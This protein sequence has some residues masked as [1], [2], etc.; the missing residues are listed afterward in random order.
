VIG[1][2]AQLFLFRWREFVRE[3]AVL[4]W[5][6]IFPLCMMGVL[7]I[8]FRPKKAE[9]VAILVS[10]D[11]PAGDRIAKDLGASPDVKVI[12][13]PPA[14]ALAAFNRGEAPLL[15]LP[16]EPPTYRYD[17]TH[18][19]SRLARLVTDGALEDARGRKPAFVATSDTTSTLGARYIDWLV[20]GII[21][22]QVMNGALWGVG[23]AIVEMRAKK[24]LKRFAVTPMKRSH[25]LLAT[26]LQRF[27]VVSL[28]AFLI[29]LFARV[30]FG[31]QVQGSILALVILVS[32]GTF[33]FASLALLVAARPRNTEVA[34]GLMNIPMLPMMVCSGV[35]FSSTRFPEV[36]QPAIK[37][38]PLTAL[39][40]GM[41]RIV[42]EGAGLEACLRE[43]AVLAAWAVV[44][45]VLALR[46]FKWT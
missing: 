18:P 31:V 5:A 30:A 42:N 46:L 11:G 39:L 41:R 45:L 14:E 24:L 29:I 20:P 22:L 10:L 43:I 23:F 7:G 12:A 38:L 2:L 34:A 40:D 44:T 15:V 16:T 27:L 28:N 13:R 1:P 36:M 17:E 19:E 25:F 8:A 32:V 21:G 6:L 3:P 35:F 9:P 4:F 26:A 33:S 37:A